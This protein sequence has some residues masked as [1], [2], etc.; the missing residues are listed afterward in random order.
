MEINTM[1]LPDYLEH[2]LMVAGALY[3]GL[4]MVLLFGFMTAGIVIGEQF[5][6]DKRMGKTPKERKP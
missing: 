1:M 4:C 6:S 3:L 5:W 2:A